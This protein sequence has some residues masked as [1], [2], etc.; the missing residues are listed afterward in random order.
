[1]SCLDEYLKRN[2]DFAAQQSAAGGLMPSLKAVYQAATAEAAEAAIRTGAD[3]VVLLSPACASFDQY[4]N[5]ERRG[6]RFRDLVKSLLEN[7]AER[8]G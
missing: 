6:D 7:P 5:F 8:Q 4:P 3:Q 2:K 1:M